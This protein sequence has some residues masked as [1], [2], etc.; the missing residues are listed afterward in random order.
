MQKRLLN[1]AKDIYRNDK[2]C[3]SG[4]YPKLFYGIS[5]KL[6][7]EISNVSDNFCS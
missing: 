7:T 1:R 5:L 3:F 2:K 6:F 4:A